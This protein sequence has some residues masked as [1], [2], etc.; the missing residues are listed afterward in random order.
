[1]SVGIVLTDLGMLLRDVGL[2][3]IPIVQVR[4][5]PR[6]TDGGGFDARRVEDVPDAVVVKAL[7]VMEHSVGEGI[8]QMVEV[9]IVDERSLSGVGGLAGCC[10]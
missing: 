5:P 7:S 1:M 4:V 3:G 2:E 9:A 8:G 6:R 10:C